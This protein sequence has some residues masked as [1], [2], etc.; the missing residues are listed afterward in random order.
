M[1]AHPIMG[2]GFLSLLLAIFFFAEGAWKI[3]LAIQ[4]R[5]S[6]AWGWSLLDGVVAV[7]LGCVIVAEW[8]ISGA[9]AI[10]LLV[11]INMLFSGWAVLMLA[12]KVRSEAPAE[13]A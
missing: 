6:R 2:L 10:G 12:A 11:G 1:F 9:W 3:I 4:V 7:V 13:V 8:P 5:P